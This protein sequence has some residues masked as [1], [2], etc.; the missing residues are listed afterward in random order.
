M[1]TDKDWQYHTTPQP[2]LAG[3]TTPWNRGKLLGGSS[4][5]NGLYLV[6]PNQIEQDSWA[7]LLSENGAEAEG[8]WKWDNVMNA[9]KK[10]ETFL[11]N[12]GQIAQTLAQADP[13]YPGAFLP[14][15]GSSHGNDGPIN[16]AWPGAMFEDVGAWL[17][18]ASKVMGLPINEDPYSGRN[19]GPFLSLSALNP[20]DW[21]RSFSR[22]AYLDPHLMRSN[23]VRN[24]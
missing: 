13:T 21:T 4:A 17:S 14:Y 20:R 16:H 3:R 18:S 23:L 8:R 2:G 5:I 6:R 19:Q 12:D 15:R 10:S 11:P 9:M 7:S 1:Y 24:A 22:N